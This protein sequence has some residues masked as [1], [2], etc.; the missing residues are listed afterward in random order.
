MRQWLDMPPVACD[1][2]SSSALSGLICVEVIDDLQEIMRR[3]VR[4][5]MGPWR[6]VNLMSNRE[7][8]R[9]CM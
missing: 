9:H 3:A 8:G 6:Y 5:F 2:A 1:A 7:R 4:I